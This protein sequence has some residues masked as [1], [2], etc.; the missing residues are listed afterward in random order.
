[1]SDKGPPEDLSKEDLW[2]RYLRSQADR[3][4]ERKR[5]LK[6]IRRAREEGVT[7]AL[8]EVL[9]AVDE[10]ERATLAAEKVKGRG[11]LKQI[12]EGLGHTRRSVQQTL[13]NIGVEAFDSVGQDFDPNRMEAL[14]R[15]PDPTLEP[16]K[17]AGELE[18]GY[19]HQGKLLR[20][21]RVAVSVK[22]DEE[23]S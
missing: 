4:N 23:A 17:V 11:G 8:R 21:A 5:H 18:R 6:E 7:Q 16:G 9:P 22:P 13:R 19:T 14:S 12:R 10:L 15:V 3:E 20:P 1:M 2:D